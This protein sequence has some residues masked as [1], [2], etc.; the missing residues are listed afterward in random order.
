MRTIALNARQANAIAQLHI[1]GI[2]TGFISSLG[3]DFVTAL[4]EAIARSESSFGYAVEDNDEVLGFV[5][6]T[7]NLNKLY[8]SVIAKSGWRFALLLARKMFSVQRVKKMFETLFYPKRIKKMDLPSAELLSIVVNP[9][10]C[11]R[12]LATQLVRKGFEHCRKMGLDKVKVLVAADNGPANKLYLKCGFK[13]VGQIDNHGVRS[14]IYQAQTKG[15]ASEN[16]KRNELS[17]PYPAPNLSEQSS[18]APIPEPATLTLFGMGWLLSR[19]WKRRGS[20]R[21]LE[22]P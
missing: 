4:Y 15:A 2:S 16:T 14:N 10:R 5:T 8:K 17:K 19:V 1:R 7:T 12:G 18:L 3:N 6:F 9:E 22:D 11:H 21:G 20:L 13:L